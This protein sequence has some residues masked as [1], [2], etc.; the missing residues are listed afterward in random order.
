M[1]IIKT[2][3]GWYM[4]LSGLVVIILIL[5]GYQQTKYNNGSNNEAV[6]NSEE[7]AI[8]VRAKPIAIKYLKDTYE[9]DVELTGE[10]LLPTYVAS[11]VI[12]K[13]NVI[14]RV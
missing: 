9:L 1:I 6:Y 14:G 10:Q 13:G 2:R 5:W 4:I 12:F 11:Q 3:F 7:Q 8:I